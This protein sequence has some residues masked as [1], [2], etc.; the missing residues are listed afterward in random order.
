MCRDSCAAFT[1]EDSELEECII[2]GKPRW[3]EGTT[4]PFK[5]YE[6]IPLIPRL[7]GFYRSQ[8][9]ADMLSYR[10]NFEHE[11][12][13]MKDVYDG[14]IYQELLNK[15]VEVDGDVLKHKFFSDPR[16]IAFALSG[17]GFQVFKETKNGPTAT[18]LMLVNYNLPPEIRTHQK[19]LIALSVIPGEHA[20]KDTN[21]FLRP[22]FDE[23]TQLARG[24]DSWDA[25]DAGE[26][27][28]LHAY[29]LDV[30][31]DTIMIAKF[32]CTRGLNGFSPCRSCL[33][34]GIY[35]VP[36][37]H[38]YFPITKPIDEPDE[39]LQSWDLP[40]LIKE[41]RR[42]HDDFISIPRRITAL[43]LKKDQNALGKHKGI[44]YESGFT[45]VPSIDMARSFPGDV[46]HIIFRHLVPNL[47]DHW[48]GKFRKL[49]GGSED[50][51]LDPEV[52][53]E[54]GELTVEASANIPQI[55]V[56]PLPNIATQRSRC[57]AE[58]YAFWIMYIAPIV[59][60]DRWEDERYYN[61]LMQLVRFLKDILKLEIKT[62]DLPRLENEIWS[63]VRT[64]EE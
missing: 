27:F 50:Y 9:M 55:F 30:I 33:I 3:H 52:W 61:H 37:H 42:K 17:D 4:T 35:H 19:H 20:P 29:D 11:P 43:P 32:M 21:S 40:R 28:Q 45:N 57:T 2:C 59:L 16:D 36:S 64:Y 48:T 13:V 25:R 24:V 14:R 22:F 8:T 1:G 31:G 26:S 44:N 12:D 62:A 46:M 23:C 5:V 39:E 10:H 38:Y 41:K 18:A 54:I 34:Q 56:K 7:Q 6:Y 60:K 15:H 51:E 58:I 53:E 63:W 49:D 47:C